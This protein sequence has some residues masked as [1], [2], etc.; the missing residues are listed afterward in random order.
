[1]PRGRGYGCNCRK[2]SPTATRPPAEKPL[3]ERVGRTERGNGPDFLS[4]EDGGFVRKSSLCPK[5][6]NQLN[7]TRRQRLPT[8]LTGPPRFIGVPARTPTPGAPTPALRPLPR[9]PAHGCCNHHRCGRPHHAALGHADRLA[10][11]H[12]LRRT[13]AQ[14]HDRRAGQHHHRQPGAQR[15]HFLRHLALLL[16]VRRPG[17]ITGSRSRRAA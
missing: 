2:S 12:R 7:R 15:S 6:C 8:R 13:R 17:A 14:R 10:I 11:D 4:A 9:Q 1:M 16:P 3:S 5:Q